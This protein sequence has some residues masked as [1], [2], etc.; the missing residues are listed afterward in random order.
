MVSGGLDVRTMNV[1]YSM[2][3]LFTRAVDIEEERGRL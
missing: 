2:I 3:S 1:G